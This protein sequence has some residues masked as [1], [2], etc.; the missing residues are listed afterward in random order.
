MRRAVRQAAALAAAGVLT[1]APAVSQGQ[2][3]HPGEQMGL[4]LRGPEVPALLKAVAADPYRAPSEP[5]CRTIPAEILALD[6][7]LGADADQAKPHKS[8]LA[9][10]AGR[11]AKGAVRG[12][13]PYRGAIRFLTR[14]D[15]KD[16]ELMTAAQAGWARRGFLRGLEASLRCAGPK[17]EVAADAAAAPRLT[18][19]TLLTASGVQRVET[20]YPAPTAAPA[21]S[22][23]A[24]ESAPAGLAAVMLAEPPRPGFEKP[25][26]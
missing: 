23:G 2:T 24:P 22:Q 18:A 20:A 7:V 6:K 12:L 19:P 1:A 14:A 10:Y 13:I 4:G 9:A 8:D 3:I 17:V 11:E 25:G 5:A 15:R 16:H 26:R 21:T